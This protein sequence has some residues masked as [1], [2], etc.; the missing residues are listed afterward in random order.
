VKRSLWLLALL[1]C[2][3]SLARQ[4]TTPLQVAAFRN[5]T[6]QVEASGLF[7][8][9]LREEVAAHGRLSESDGPTLQGELLALRSAPS[10]PGA[11]GA[12]AFRLDA[13]LLLRVVDA[14]GAVSYEDRA[15]FGEDYLTGVDVLGT[16]ANRRAALRRLARAA[17]R[18]LL[19]RFEIA[20][21]VR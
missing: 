3:Y 9:A 21:R 18:E 2:G 12:Q 4:G 19:E 17:S 10:G 11:S 16:E 5:Y 14:R 1:G 6:A 15:S 13:D 8:M 20:R 7:A